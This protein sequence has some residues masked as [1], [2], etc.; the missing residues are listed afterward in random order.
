MFIV[1]ILIWELKNGP[2]KLQTKITGHGQFCLQWTSTSL[3]DIYIYHRLTPP[4][5]ESES[6]SHSKI[7]WL[8]SHSST[9]CILRVIQSHYWTVIRLLLLDHCWTLQYPIFSWKKIEL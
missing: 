9:A 3:G 1:K 5:D 6:K 4:N 7:G 2:I 8:V